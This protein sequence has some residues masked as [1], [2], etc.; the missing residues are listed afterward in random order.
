MIIIDKRVPARIIIFEPGDMI[1]DSLGAVMHESGVAYS[2]QRLEETCD[3]SE[4][5]KWT[6]EERAYT[7]AIIGCLPR[8][9]LH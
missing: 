2:I 5:A 6:T 3:D 1:P 7:E 4:N 9:L 8:P